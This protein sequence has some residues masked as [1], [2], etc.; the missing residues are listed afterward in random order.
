MPPKIDGGWTPPP[1]VVLQHKSNLKYIFGPQK[2]WAFGRVA[3]KSL[4]G[5]GWG[6]RL[7]IELV[8]GLSWTP[9]TVI[10]QHKSKL[11]KM[12]QKK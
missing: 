10:L 5:G 12:S 3:N 1:T 9:P 4:V 2:N 11:K 7:R 6:V 8:A